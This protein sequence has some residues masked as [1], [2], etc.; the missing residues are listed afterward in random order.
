MSRQ[1]QIANPQAMAN[2]G[3]A[4]KEFGPSYAKFVKELSKRLGYDSDHDAISAQSVFR[5]VKGENAIPQDFAEMVGEAFGLNYKWILGK[6]DNKTQL[7]EAEERV[8]AFMNEK[9]KRAQLFAL[10]ADLQGWEVVER[11]DVAAPYTGSGDAYD[12]T[13]AIAALMDKYVKLVRGD[14]VVSVGYVE[15]GKLIDKM[16]GFFDV[17]L[18]CK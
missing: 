8:S 18:A 2:L 14:E 7:D 10:L 5:Y 9:A 1:R 4:V 3:E 13:P 11:P 15:Y 17:E 6:S 16:G 12:D